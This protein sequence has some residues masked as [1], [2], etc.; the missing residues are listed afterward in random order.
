MGPTVAPI[1]MAETG[2]GMHR[3]RMAGH[4]VSWAGLC[5]RQAKSAGTRLSTLIPSRATCRDPPL[6][7]HHVGRR[8]DRSTDFHAQLLRLRS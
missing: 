5:L 7:S 3:Y 4:F 6:D 1:T 2:V 8:P